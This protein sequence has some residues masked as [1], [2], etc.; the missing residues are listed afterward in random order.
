MLENL[1]AVC[2]SISGRWIPLLSPSLRLPVVD[3]VRN[4]V[5]RCEFMLLPHIIRQAV[6]EINVAKRMHYHGNDR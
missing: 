6:V 3:N 4:Q 5:V 1:N 2:A